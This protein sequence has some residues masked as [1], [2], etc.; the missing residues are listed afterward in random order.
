MPVQVTTH[1]STDGAQ[2]ILSYEL[3]NDSGTLSARVID[4]G[5]TL[6]HLVAT[7]RAGDKRDIVLGFD[8][9][10][11]VVKVGQKQ[12]PYFGSLVGRSC[13]RTAHG[14]FT[15]NATEYTLPVN[16]GPNALH[17]G[18]V[19]FD[20]RFW[21]SRIVSQSP[22]RIAL[23]LT[24]LDGDQGYPG[25]LHVTVEY[26]LTATDLDITYAAALDADTPAGLRTYVNLTSHPYFNLDGCHVPTVHD[27]QIAMPGVAGH[28]AL[29]N[30]Q[31]P[32][33]EM[34]PFS[35]PTHTAH[36]FRAA[37]P[38]SADLHAVQQ[39]RGYDHYYIRASA[40]DPSLALLAVAESKTSGLSLS[41]LTT[42]AGFQFY[43]GN[44]LDGGIG[45]K[46]T[47]PG[48][49][50]YGAYAGFCMEPS[51]PPNGINNPAYAS[52]VTIGAGET[53]SQRAVYRIGGLLDS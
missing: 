51:A 45:G 15:L 39:F 44:W 14:K 22:P 12:N 3:T 18:I 17:G 49:T 43:T 33:G 32:T 48:G 41:L 42:A 46:A 10:F 38:V 11:D 34:V 13:N 8:D 53:W 47:Q 52:L 35:S 5:A 1:T 29:D 24:S 40:A 23:T 30:H 37:K 21:S 6:T 16:N 27:T 20:K 7:T 31:I 9:P 2:T 36:D 25:T 4:Y 19:G 26:T 28:L 50:T